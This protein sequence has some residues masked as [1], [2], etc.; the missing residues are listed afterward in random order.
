[1]AGAEPD[2]DAVALGALLA[3]YAIGGAFYGLH[4]VMSQTAVR[5]AG[6]GHGPANACLL[7]HTVRALARRFPERLAEID[8]AM[9]EDAA[10]V[11]ARLAERAGAIRLR[12]LGVPAEALAR[13]ADVAS[14]R[15]EL[16]LTPPPADRDE[17]LALYEEAW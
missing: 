17:L 10:S 5:E 4:H 2:R 6:V 15:S 12:D 8:E 13:C 1:M 16:N 7:P 3:G 9:G 14:A 11:A